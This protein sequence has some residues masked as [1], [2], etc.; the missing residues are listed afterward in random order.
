[1]A[2]DA[3]LNGQ[4][5]R[6]SLSE[7][8]DRLDGIIDALDGCLGE[9]VAD[10]VNKAAAEAARQTAEIVAGQKLTNN[11]AASARAVQAAAPPFLTE[12]AR[13]ACQFAWRHRLAACASL[14]AAL[15]SLAASHLVG[16]AASSLALAACGAAAGAAL[17]CRPRSS[18]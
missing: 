10:A 14:S 4:P 13:L 3:K 12:R 18:P 6:K 8:L 1:M 15:A 5:P 11:E 16:S 17:A 9:V 7:Q 2:N